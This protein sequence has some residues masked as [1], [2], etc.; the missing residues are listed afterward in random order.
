MQ[1]FCLVQLVGET[2]ED[3]WM[4]EA[5]VAFNNILPNVVS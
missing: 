3:E 4:K 5:S 2:D 1:Q